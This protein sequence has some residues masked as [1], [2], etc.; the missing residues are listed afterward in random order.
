M[1]LLTSV[2]SLVSC[3]RNDTTTS[4]VLKKINSISDTLDI[5]PAAGFE[6]METELFDSSKMTEYENK[7]LEL[8][9]FKAEDKN[10]VMH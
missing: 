4:D 1:I 10:Y 7:R 3:S 9:R 5:D 8:L 6:M 2:Q